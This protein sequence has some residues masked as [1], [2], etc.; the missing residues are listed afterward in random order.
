MIRFRLKELIAARAFK[1]GRVIT[2]LEIAQSTGIHRA[3]LSKIAHERGYNAGTEYVDRLCDYF[4]CRIEELLE[5]IPNT[6]STAGPK[7]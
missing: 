7:N 4:D 2:L 6:T 5:R 1:E 3:T